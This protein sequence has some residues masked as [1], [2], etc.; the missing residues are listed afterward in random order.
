MDRL[1]TPW[2]YSYVSRNPAGARA[3]VPEALSG[4]PGDLG[5]VF[6]NM[7]AAADYGIAQGMAWDEAEMAAGIVYRGR[8]V[9]V[10]LN[11]FPYATGHVMLLP[12]VHL[13]SLAKLSASTATE[14]I[15]LAQATETHLRC[16][17]TPEGINFGMN[18]GE[19][20]GAGVAAHLHL[21]VLPRWIG[22]TN[23]MT[24]T[25]ETRV[26]PE[27]LDTT[28]RRL[29]EAFSEVDGSGK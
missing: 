23:F 26:L 13:D 5:C 9:F 17:Y 10:C 19:A 11:A 27:T 1:W 29:R 24:V 2:R 8:E 3:G 22:D 15:L 4:W 16:I 25:A 14:L 18:I 20:A 6:C 28:W 7:I 12:Y 21:H